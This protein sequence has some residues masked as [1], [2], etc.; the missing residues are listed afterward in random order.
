MA[1]FA[2]AADLKIILTP[3]GTPLTILERFLFLVASIP[4]YQDRY[5][6]GLQALLRRLQFHLEI[7]TICFYI[8]ESLRYVLHKS[9]SGNARQSTVIRSSNFSYDAPFLLYMLDDQANLALRV[10]IEQMF[11]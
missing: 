2:Y 4:Y 10:H 1:F 6:I 9:G 5:V 7:K 8:S 11:C 3:T